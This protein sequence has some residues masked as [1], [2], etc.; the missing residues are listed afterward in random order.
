MTIEDWE[1]TQI[2]AHGEGI[3]PDFTTDFWDAFWVA[4]LIWLAEQNNP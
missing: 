2:G 3:E 4:F 1:F